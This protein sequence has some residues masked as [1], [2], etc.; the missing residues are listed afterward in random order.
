MAGFTEEESKRK[1]QH[2]LLPLSVGSAK[3]LVKR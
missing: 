1:T 2:P 3:Q